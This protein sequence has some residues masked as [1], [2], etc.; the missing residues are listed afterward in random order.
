[1]TC[2]VLL[3]FSQNHLFFCDVHTSHGLHESFHCQNID[4]FGACVRRHKL[5]SSEERRHIFKFVRQSPI[6]V[7]FTKTI[8]CFRLCCIQHPHP[9]TTFSHPC[10]ISIYAAI[11]RFSDH[12]GGVPTTSSQSDTVP[13]WPPC[14]FCH[15]WR[16]CQKGGS[17]DNT[18]SDTV[19]NVLSGTCVKGEGI[20]SWTW[21][22]TTPFPLLPVTSVMKIC[23]FGLGTTEAKCDTLL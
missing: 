9:A 15:C 14:P 6:K 3:W 10:P 8:W 1:M 21:S 23:S 18:D 13:L 2:A 22:I 17:C 5:W 20:S 4:I 16:W 12:I 11:V 19:P 7:Y